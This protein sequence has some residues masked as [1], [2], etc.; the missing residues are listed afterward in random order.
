MLRYSSFSLLVRKA[1]IARK[2]FLEYESDSIY[3]TLHGHI[4]NII[5]VS[6][7]HQGPVVS[8]AF[9]LNGG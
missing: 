9:S 1:S 4:I 6:F 7:I 5:K 2:Y 8:K 3:A